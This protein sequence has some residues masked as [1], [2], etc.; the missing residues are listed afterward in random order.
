MTDTSTTQMH[1]A[2]ADHIITTE[3]KRARAVDEKMQALHAEQQATGICCAGCKQTLPAIMF[4]KDKS[5]KS[6]IAARCKPCNREHIKGFAGYV[7]KERNPLL[8]PPR[9]TNIM[10]GT[11]VPACDTYYRNDGLKHIKSLGF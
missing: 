9:Q 11:Y 1:T 7:K 2:N 8:V 6:G 5:R 3:A 10:Q 4:G